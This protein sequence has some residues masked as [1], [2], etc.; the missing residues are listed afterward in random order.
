[1]DSIKAMLDSDRFATPDEIMAIKQY[2]KERYQTDVEV[3][4]RAK[5]IVIITSSAGLANSLRLELPQLQKAAGTN[6][7]LLFRI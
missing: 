2:V 1:M 6:K 3:L 4:I 7:K 5:D